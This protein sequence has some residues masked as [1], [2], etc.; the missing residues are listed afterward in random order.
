MNAGASQKE[1]VAAWVRDVI[2]QTGIKATPLAKAAGLA[3]ST[4]LRTLD[5]ENPGYL[6]AASIGKIVKKFG[7]PPPDLFG[8]ASSRTGAPSGFPEPELRELD[9]PAQ[10]FAGVSLTPNQFVRAVATRALELAGYLP[11]D[12]VLIDMALAPGADDVVIA[13]VYNLERGTA[14]TVL[15]AYDPPYLVVRTADPRCRAKPL[16]ADGTQVK[17]MGTVVRA[18]RLRASA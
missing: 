8:G 9:A 1:I 15:R 3:P 14:E 7:M 17:I 2:R 13:Q 16:L 11:G 12:L 6:D 10:S 4:L 18:L 5:P